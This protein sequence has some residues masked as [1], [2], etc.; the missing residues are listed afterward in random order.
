MLLSPPIYVFLSCEKVLPLSV[1][2]EG[3][4]KIIQIT[5]RN[6]KLKDRLKLQFLVFCSCTKLPSFYSCSKYIYKSL[7]MWYFLFS[8]EGNSNT[9]QYFCL[10]DPTDRGAWKATAHAVTRLSHQHHLLFSEHLHPRD[11]HVPPSARITISCAWEP[12]SPSFVC[13]QHGH[14]H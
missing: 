14:L 10:E 5:M 4:S 12:A 8:G 11:F 6:L 1:I 3:L 13:F 7:N 2:L 9:L